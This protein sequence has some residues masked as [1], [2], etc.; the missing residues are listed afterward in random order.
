MVDYIE[1]KPLS[2]FPNPPVMELLLVSIHDDHGDT[3]YDYTDVGWMTCNREYWIVENEINN[4]VVAWAQF[5]KPYR[6]RE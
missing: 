5:P 2:S 4:F 6:G 3:P 1:W